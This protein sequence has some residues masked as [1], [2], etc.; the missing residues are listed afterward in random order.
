MITVSDI[1][2][3]ESAFFVVVT[4]GFLSGFCSLEHCIFLLF[5][6]EEESIIRVSQ[7]AR[8]KH[9]HVYK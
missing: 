3:L 9:I 7:T 5:S 1:L 6:Q 4:C 8:H 2:A